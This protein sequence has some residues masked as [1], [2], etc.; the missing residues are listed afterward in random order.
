MIEQHKN[1][2]AELRARWSG[3][4]ESED[5]Q[6]FSALLGL[7]ELAFTETERLAQDPN[8]SPA[9]RIFSGRRIAKVLRPDMVKAETRFANWR[10]QIAGK[11]NALETEVPKELQEEVS[12]LGAEIRAALRAMPAGDRGK[13]LASDRIALAAALA[14]PAWLSGVEPEMLAELARV[15]NPKLAAE[16]ARAE[17]LLEVSGVAVEVAW[18]ALFQL[19]GLEGREAEAFRADGTLPAQKAA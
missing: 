15:S 3:S 12:A 5:W 17:P 13:L 14:A 1:M 11:R 18:G 16:I 8:L 4:R 7:A 19:A 6:R 10:G 2:I 9:G